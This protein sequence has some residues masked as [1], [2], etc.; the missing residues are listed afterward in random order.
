MPSPDERVEFTQSDLVAALW[1]AGWKLKVKTQSGGYTWRFTLEPMTDADRKLD[2]DIATH[3]G[4]L[5]VV[6]GH[7]VERERQRA[8]MKHYYAQDYGERFAKRLAGTG[9]FLNNE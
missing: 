5:N 4:A 1:A 6:S 3:I 2:P 7:V 9:G 8:A